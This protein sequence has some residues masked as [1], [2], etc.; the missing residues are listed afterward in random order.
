MLSAA[1]IR[2]INKKY[3]PPNMLNIL[4]ATHILYTT[5]RFCKRFHIKSLITFNV[6]FRHYF[7]NLICFLAMLSVFPFLCLCNRKGNEKVLWR[8][9]KP[10]L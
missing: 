8:A 1:N 9:I 2:K 6:F 7:F 3:P 5:V 10:N 4:K